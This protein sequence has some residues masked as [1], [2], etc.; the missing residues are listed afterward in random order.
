[1]KKLILA[2]LALCCLFVAQH[3][4]SQ[5]MGSNSSYSQN[6]Q[7]NALFFSACGLF[8]TKGLATNGKVYIEGLYATCEYCRANFKKEF[9]LFPPRILFKTLTAGS[10]I[11]IIQSGDCQSSI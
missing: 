11:N 7:T 8:Q 6:P 2:G 4:Y 1:M 9:P 10:Q 5:D 3:S